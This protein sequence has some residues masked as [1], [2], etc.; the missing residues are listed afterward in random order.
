MTI[1][2]DKNVTDQVLDSYKFK[3]KENK[4]GSF[5]KNV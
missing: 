2:T 3:Y 1:K 4:N 5:R